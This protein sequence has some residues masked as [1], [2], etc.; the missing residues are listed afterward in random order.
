[1]ALQFRKRVRLQDDSCL[2]ESLAEAGSW[3][4]ALATLLAGLG[5]AAA[6]PMAHGAGSEAQWDEALNQLWQK[7]NPTQQQELRQEKRR[8]SKWKDNLSDEGDRIRALQARI[9]YL[10]QWD[11]DATKE[12]EEAK[13]RHEE[14]IRSGLLATSGEE[15][16]APRTTL[17][18]T[19]AP[20]TSPTPTPTVA[21]GLQPGTSDIY[22]KPGVGLPVSG[23]QLDSPEMK[24]EAE[25]NAA[26]ARAQQQR[27]EEIDTAWAPK[28]TEPSGGKLNQADFER[29]YKWGIHFARTMAPEDAM[30]EKLLPK[31]AD[32]D[33]KNNYNPDEI[34]SVRS[35]EAGFVQ[36]VAE[37]R[38]VIPA[39]HQ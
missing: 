20:E 22:H 7:L 3:R 21:R 4:R 32:M 8:W 13:K 30:F 12:T 18:P 17:V 24:A 16:P 1:M 38:D 10:S 11:P 19:P 27:R 5:M 15:Q 31:Y 23:T 34:T 33:M 39:S 29:G 25:R 9:D 26:H 14:W 2:E 35:F 37:I 28:M 36:G 6:S